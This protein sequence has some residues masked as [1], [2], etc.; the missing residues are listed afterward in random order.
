MSM[1]G[2]SGERA[3]KNT[4]AGLIDPDR[5]CQE[6]RIAAENAD[7]ET[8]AVGARDATWEPTATDDEME[9][10]IPCRDHPADPVDSL[11]ILRVELR[12]E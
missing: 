1:A 7:I 8:Y 11:G 12:P 10:K 9:L 2:A 5:E 4:L 3:V 6:E